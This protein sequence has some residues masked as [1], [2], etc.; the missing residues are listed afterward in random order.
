MT[1]NP[2]AYLNLSGLAAAGVI[3]VPTGGAQPF[4]AV[5][6]TNRTAG[7]TGYADE[8]VTPYVQSFNLSVQRE[9][10]QNT[11]LDISW[12]GNKATKLF[13][14]TQLN[15][16]NIFENGLLDAFNVTRAGGDAPLFNQLLNGL[17]VNPGTNPALG[18]GVVN[19]TTLTGSKALRSF[20]TTNTFIANGDVGGLANFINTTNQF[21]G[22]NGANGVNGGLLRNGGLSENFIVVNPQFGS[23]SLEG[24]NSSSTYHSFQTVLTRRMTKG[25]Y[26]QFSYTFSKALGDNGVRDPRNRQ[27]SKG[28]LGIDRP[29]IVK[30]NGTYELPFGANHAYL[31]GAPNYIQQIVGNWELSSVFSWVTGAPLTFTGTNTLAFRAQNTADLVG[32]LPDNLGKVE[33]SNGGVVQYFSGLKVGA[34]PL[35]N[36]GGDPTL[37]GRFTNQAVTD[38]AGNI[39]LQSP[40]PGTTGNTAINLP[41]LHGPSNLGLDVALN[42]KFVLSE[43]KTFSIRADAVNVLNTPVWG[44][45]TTNINSANFGRITTAGGARAVTISGRID[46]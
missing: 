3:P 1:Y 12:I 25:L 23:V 32:A 33:K 2:P 19:G 5:P 24:N 4:T 43:G 38:L 29:Q 26:T 39:I 14:A 28:I 31:N 10:T 30:A 35:P 15:E 42:K 21:T 18:Q 6:L 11:T 13:S 45:P 41:G 40:Q 34:A 36:F 27:L 44:N 16:T 17:T 8:R 46:F 7:I 22:V 37:P 20:A 9:L